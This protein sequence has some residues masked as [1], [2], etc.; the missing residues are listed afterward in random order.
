MKLA[1]VSCEGLSAK[2]LFCR[3]GDVYEQQSTLINS[4][5]NQMVHKEGIPVRT[6]VM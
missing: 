4:V 5:L 2:E 1:E 6:R 3:C